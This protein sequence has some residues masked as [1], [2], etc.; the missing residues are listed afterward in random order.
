MSSINCDA[1]NEPF[2]YFCVNSAWHC[3]PLCKNCLIDHNKMHNKNKQ[4]SD[5]LDFKVTI[6]KC[7]NKAISICKEL[8]ETQ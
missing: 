1:H 8:E 3:E 7:E 2:L 5:L 6:A 4:F